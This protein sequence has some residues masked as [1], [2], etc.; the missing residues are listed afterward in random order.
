MGRFTFI[1]FL[2][3]T[4]L[5]YLFLFLVCHGVDKYGW[6]FFR[7]MS[8]FSRTEKRQWKN[9]NE[10]SK[11]SVMRSCCFA[12]CYF[13][14]RIGRLNC[15]C[16]SLLRRGYKWRLFWRRLTWPFFDISVTFRATSNPSAYFINHCLAILSKFLGDFFFWKDGLNWGKY[17]M[18][19][20]WWI[21]KIQIWSEEW[22]DLY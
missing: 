15:C 7:Q 17:E 13:V 22:L 8:Y 16:R 5:P 3:I 4:N 20:I 18:L 1:L 11:M 10:N 19:K 14:L 2:I 9:K 12:S 21:W 6:L